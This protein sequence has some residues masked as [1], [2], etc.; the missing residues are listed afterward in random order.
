MVYREDKPEITVR[1]I[2]DLKIKLSPD[3][4]VGP[5]IQQNMEILAMESTY[6]KLTIEQKKTF[7]DYW[8]DVP[9]LPNQIHGKRAIECADR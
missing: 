2:Y 3:G 4:I 5:G 6:S 7:K 8:V 9:E 1:R